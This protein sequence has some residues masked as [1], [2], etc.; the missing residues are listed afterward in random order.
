MHNFEVYDTSLSSPVQPKG[1]LLSSNASIPLLCI[2]TC[3]TLSTGT[4]QAR[5]YVVYVVG[6]VFRSQSWIR[7]QLSYLCPLCLESPEMSWYPRINEVQQIGSI[8][9]TTLQLKFQ[10]TGRT[11]TEVGI[12]H[13]GESTC[14]VVP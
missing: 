14:L 6:K 1:G 4:K 2:T 10:A 9:F 5:R 12:V 3:A 13:G 7:E 11:T 8:V